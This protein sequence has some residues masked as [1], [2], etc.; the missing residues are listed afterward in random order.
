MS[1]DAPR[2]VAAATGPIDGHDPYGAFARDLVSRGYTPR[3]IETKMYGLR[4]FERW[5]AERPVACDA[6]DERTIDAFLRTQRD[7][8][9]RHGRTLGDF[10]AHLRA[11][12]LAALPPPAPPSLVDGWLQRYERHLR[13]ERGLCQTT[14]ATHLWVARPFLAQHLSAAGSVSLTA[15]DVSTY[16]QGEVAKRSLPRAKHVVW[17]L[18]ALLRYLFQEGY[19]RDLSPAVLTVR[20]W[21]LS[22]MPKA[23]PPP[24]VE[25]VLAA[26]PRDTAIGRR[27]RAILLLLARL[28]LRAGEVVA[29]EL[30]DLDWRAGT[31]SIRAK[32]GLRQERLPLPVDVGRAVATY[33]RRDRPEGVGRRVFLR[34]RAP[35]GGFR[36]TSGVGS[37]VQKALARAD[38]HPPRRGAHL[39]RHSLA[40]RML[41]HGA[42]FGEIGAVLR[43]RGAASTE[44]YAKVDLARLRAVVQPWPGSA[45]GAQ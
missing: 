25:R 13:V 10:L 32:K 4:A 34:V 17:V 19:T 37:V 31:I 7:G 15:A 20:D 27:D 3:T 16:L 23:L 42:S 21:R 2:C 43:H 45:G 8:R 22:T 11:A 30:D 36:G 9:A 40:V 44:I 35:R 39:L 38:L 1:D 24:D 33:L 18:R 14:I 12:G 26:C 29:L 28:G 5:L 6:V 41:G